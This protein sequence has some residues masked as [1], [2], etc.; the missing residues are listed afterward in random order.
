[1]EKVT[2]ASSA[3]VRQWL[4]L[5]SLFDLVEGAAPGAVDDCLSPSFLLKPFLGGCIVREHLKLDQGDPLA[6]GGPAPLL[7][8]SDY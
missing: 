6:L 2:A 7:F 8:R 4:A 3:P 5:G 1:M